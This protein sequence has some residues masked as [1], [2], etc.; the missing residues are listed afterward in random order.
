MEED[1]KKKEWLT[2][3]KYLGLQTRVHTKRDLSMNTLNYVIGDIWEPVD[4]YH[5][6]LY[7]IMSEGSFKPGTRTGTHSISIG[8]ATMDY[9]LGSDT[10]VAINTKSVHSTSVLTELEFFMKG[11]T[12]NNWL[13]DRGVSI[14]NEW[15]DPETGDL[16]PIYGAQWRNF[17]GVDQLANVFDSLKNDP[18]SRRHVV[19]A[20]NPPEIGNMALPPCH[21]MFQFDVQR[22]V[23][24]KYENEGSDVFR[25]E[26][27][28]DDIRLNLSVYQR[29]MDVFLGGP[30]NLMSYSAM[31]Q[32]FAHS[33][34]YKTGKLTYHIGDAHIYENHFSQV[35]LQLIR[36]YTQPMSDKNQR[37]NLFIPLAGYKFPW[38][39][40]AKDLVVHVPVKNNPIIAPVAV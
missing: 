40:N 9:H 16:G 11:I 13:K 23:Y 33:L 22:E 12:N 29:S 35:E 32:L 10:I 4:P 25:E 6:V 31:L 18:F 3:E 39:F 14:W 15:A 30:F 28:S 27:Y 26:D 1:M 37:G 36:H 7:D 19:S 24:N 21:V 2:T 5:R 34:G 17:G 38:D 8:S 20:W